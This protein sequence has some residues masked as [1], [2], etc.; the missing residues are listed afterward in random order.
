M[1]PEPPQSAR[2]KEEPAAE[3]QPEKA[4]EGESRAEAEAAAQETRK[5]RRRGKRGGRRRRR[6]EPGQALADAGEP[7]DSV[8][9]PAPEGQPL[10]PEME[11]EAPITAEPVSIVA[12]TR[13][14]ESVWD[15]SQPSGAAD[16][17]ADQPSPVL[18]PRSELSAA[19]RTEEVPASR[20]QA[21]E[22]RV[23]AAAVAQE[24]DRPRRRGWWQRV[25]E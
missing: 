21:E 25:L 9:E 4:E 12:S 19:D 5:R 22:R 10:L 15:E 7:A 8:D 24:P 1:R 20:Q 11:Q 13:P 16:R 23:P 18:E 3:A 14:A 2:T 17:R 6:S